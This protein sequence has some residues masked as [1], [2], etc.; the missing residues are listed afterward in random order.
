[1]RAGTAMVGSGGGSVTLYTAVV[2]DPGAAQLPSAQHHS[3]LKG[4]VTL[5]STLSRTQLLPRSPILS[6]IRRLVELVT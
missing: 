1:M 6:L 5:K 4:S 3:T 2:P